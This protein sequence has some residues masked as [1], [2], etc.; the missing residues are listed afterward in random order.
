MT[1]TEQLPAQKV[2]FPSTVPCTLWAPAPLFL[3]MQ[4]RPVVRNRSDPQGSLCHQ[5]LGEGEN[6]YEKETR[7]LMEVLGGLLKRGRAVVLSGTILA[8]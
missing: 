2:S 8:S 3:G 7:M 5:E 4:H 6:A 1:S